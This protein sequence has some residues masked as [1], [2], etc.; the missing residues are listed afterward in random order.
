MRILL[1]H[2]PAGVTA[3]DP[4]LGEPLGTSA[5]VAARLSELLPG[6]TFDGGRG[7]FRR[8][9]YELIFT[10]AGDEPT[11][12]EV[13]VDRSEGLTALKRIVD[14]TG[15][16]A[17]DPNGPSFVDLDARRE[18]QDLVAERSTEQ[19]PAASRN[20]VGVARGTPAILVAWWVIAAVVVAVV[21]PKLP[22]LGPQWVLAAAC[23]AIAQWLILRPYVSWAGDWGGATAIQAVLQ[24]LLLLAAFG[25]TAWGQFAPWSTAVGVACLLASA[26]PQAIV[27][28]RRAHRATIWLSSRLIRYFV[29]VA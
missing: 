27:L 17:I 2:L 18:K 7:T 3:P 4:A 25:G 26:V 28:W 5:R 8:A 19:P 10:I 6:T 1:V 12:V 23:T 20:A 22:A 9:S 29:P 13:E 11:T 14:K 15:W 16:R 24:Y 21:T